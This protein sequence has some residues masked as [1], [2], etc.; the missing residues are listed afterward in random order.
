MSCVSCRISRAAAEARSCRTRKIR[1]IIPIRKKDRNSTH[2]ALGLILQ[3]SYA[4]LLDL[5]LK[6]VDMVRSLNNLQMAVFWRLRTCP[7]S[8][9]E[10]SCLRSLTCRSDSMRCM[11][12]S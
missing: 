5:A 1:K 9:N 2:K 7:Y 4:R 6:S 12:D 10:P 11:I 8:H 3:V